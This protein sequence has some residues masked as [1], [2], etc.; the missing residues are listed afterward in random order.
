MNDI[1]NGLFRDQGLSSGCVIN[2]SRLQLYLVL[3]RHATWRLQLLQ[4]CVARWHYGHAQCCGV[5][6]HDNGAFSALWK[7]W[8]KLMIIATKQ[9]SKEA[10]VRSAKIKPPGEQNKILLEQ[11]KENKKKKLKELF[12]LQLPVVQFNV[13]VNF[14]TAHVFSETAAHRKDSKENWGETGRQCCLRKCGLEKEKYVRNVN[15][16]NIVKFGQFSI[17]K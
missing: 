4:L 9:L 16:A 8:I 7:S 15:I 10:C 11:R 6:N 17:C 12:N 14:P 2:K 5:I 1:R 13:L 3:S